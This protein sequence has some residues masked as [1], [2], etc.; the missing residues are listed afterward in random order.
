MSKVVLENLTKLFGSVRA[1]DHLSL[2]IQDGMFVTLLGPSGCGKTTTLNCI[3]GLERPTEGKIYLEGECINHLAPYERG[4]AM[5]FQ[6]YALYPHMDVFANIAFSLK[7]K[8]RPKKEIEERVRTITSMLEI[9]EFLGRKPWQLSG[10]QQ[11]RVALGRALIKRP[12]V[13]L[14]DEPLSNL[15]AALRD[16]MRM[17]IKKLH[18]QLKSTSIF[19]THDQEEAMT[20]SDCI[21]VMRN[22]KLAQYD[23]PEVVY[24]WPNSLYVAT[25]IGKPRMNL[26]RGVLNRENG[27]PLFRGDG[28]R[29]I[30]PEQPVNWKMTTGDVVVGVR[31]EDVKLLSS[32]N[33]VPENMLR[34]RVTLTVPT[35]SYTFV[36][37]SNDKISLLVR[38]NP[39]QQFTLEQPVL[40]HFP[41]NKFHVFDSVT[42]SRIELEGNPG[43]KRPS[44]VGCAPESLRA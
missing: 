5:V 7:L 12:K 38:V 10:G 29:V 34:G 43:N 22:G 3:A 37:V 32:D 39:D 36:E 19:V 9:S 35:G 25:F 27:R 24:R 44:R 15:D 16:R 20:L 6:N 14:F 4:M 30:W 31:P 28:I 18:L 8:R 41:A 2:E 17:E 26:V 21:A 13:F 42:E 1:V 33:E 40:V 11:Q 23:T